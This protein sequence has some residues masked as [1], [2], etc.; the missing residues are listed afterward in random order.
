MTGA[1]DHTFF[2][3][4]THY[5]TEGSVIDLVCFG[6]ETVSPKKAIALKYKN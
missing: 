2:V 5:D 4:A 1:V 6:L 3:H